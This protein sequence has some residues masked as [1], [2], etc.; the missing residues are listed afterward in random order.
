LLKITFVLLA[1]SVSSPAR[2]DEFASSP[3]RAG[4]EPSGRL[5]DFEARRRMDVERGV[6]PMLTYIVEAFAAPQL[7]NRVVTTGL[8][9]LEID[10]ALD[11]L[12]GPGW[13]AAYASG[14]A[15]HG[16]G[17]T[18]ELMD[19]HG[20][21]GN[22]APEDVRLFEAWIEQPVGPFTLRAGLL[23]ADQ[24][25]VLAEHSSTLMSATFGITS[26]FSANILG[27]VYP[28]GT[29]GASARLELG[30][31]TARLAVYDGTQSNDHGIP[32]DLGPSVLVLGELHA[33]FLKLGAW[34]HDERDT[35][36]YA[37]ADAQL[38]RYV[39]AFARAGYSP[40]AP[41]VHYI[42]AGIRVT[43]GPRR[44]ADFVSAG[45]AFATTDEGA[46]IVVEATYELQLRLLA[47]QPGLQLVMLRDRTV[48]V[49]ATRATIVF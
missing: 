3:V 46:Q 31:V 34:Y 35:G 9:M 40:D 37:I 20:V 19:V 41:V 2:A 30:T 45:I 7:D 44:P 12:I 10:V 17:L 26:Q 18:D 27:P 24:E 47:L 21:S 43:P 25:L 8:L 13:G 39:G 1:A 22:A 32:S 16:Q 49:L 36:V 4:Y 38:E 42:D 23:A 15:V 28:V 14:L 5:L 11:K 48:G 29:P 33:S 6:D